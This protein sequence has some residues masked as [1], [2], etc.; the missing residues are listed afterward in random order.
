M[1]EWSQ[2]ANVSSLIQIA[3]TNDPKGL[4]YMNET[5]L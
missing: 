2:N 5:S 1:V 3:T 4:N